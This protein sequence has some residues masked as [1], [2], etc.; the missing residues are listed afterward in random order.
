MLTSTVCDGANIHKAN[1]SAKLAL[2]YA[3]QETTNLDVES[4][5]WSQ[6]SPLLPGDYLQTLYQL[7]VFGFDCYKECPVALTAVF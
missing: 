5:H 4:V 6:C 3:E 7:L 2:H 1:V